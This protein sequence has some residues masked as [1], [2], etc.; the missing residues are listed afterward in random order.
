LRLWLKS[1]ERVG[2]CVGCGLVPEE[3]VGSMG[4]I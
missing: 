2:A 4:A 1:L 3:E